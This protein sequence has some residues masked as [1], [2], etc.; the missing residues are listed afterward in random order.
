M[1]IILRLKNTAGWVMIEWFQQSLLPDATA[2]MKHQAEG[3]AWASLPLA[4]LERPSHWLCN[5]GGRRKLRPVG[6]PKPLRFLLTEGNSIHVS[7]SRQAKMCE[8]DG[9]GQNGIVDLISPSSTVMFPH[10]LLLWR[11][12]ILEMRVS[13]PQKHFRHF[14]EGGS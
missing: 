2:R 13:L 9:H 4:L 5:L 12:D 10:I 8:R 6:N 7:F 3:W 14:C 1:T 11:V